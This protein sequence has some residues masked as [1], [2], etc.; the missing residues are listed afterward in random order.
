MTQSEMALKQRGFGSTMRPDAWWVQ[1]ALVFTGLSIFVVYS[2]WAAFQGEHYFFGPYLSPFYS[3]ELFGPSHHAWF[4]TQPSWWPSAIKFS[5][6]F[7]ILWIPAGFRGTCYY[8]RG[9]Y[10][11]AFWAD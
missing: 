2:T 11:K 10:Y 3:P 9:A 7:F 5:P 4:G 8:Y 1:P 6:A